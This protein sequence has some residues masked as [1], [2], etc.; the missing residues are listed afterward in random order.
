MGTLDFVAVAR[1]S[2]GL[3]VAAVLG[4]LI[5]IQRQ[6]TGKVAGFR[7]H[8]LVAVGSCAFAEVSRLAGDTR[9]AAGVI[10]GIGFL[11]AG[12]IVREGATPRGLTT[13]ASI[14]CAAAVGLGAGFG[15]PN[16]FALAFVTT[17]LVLAALITS[18][19]F[20]ERFFPPHD[21]LDACVVFDADALTVDDVH[22]LFTAHGVHA[23]KSIQLSIER[24]DLQRY[25]RWHLTLRA[26]HGGSLRDA[27]LEVSKN[28]A[29]HAIEAGGEPVV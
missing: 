12:A 5:G 10:T 6:V 19:A 17:A 24:R 1:L 23:K 3:V 14:W 7:T 21:S 11:G 16:D 15:T 13:A 29:I 26:K 2:E 9:I 20:L 18:D 4:G 22:G 28:R 25:A 27:L 8:L